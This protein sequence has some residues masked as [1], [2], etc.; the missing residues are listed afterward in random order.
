MEIFGKEI[1]SEMLL[2]GTACLA[3]VEKRPESQF[4]LP[5]RTA[6]EA[7]ITKSINRLAQKIRSD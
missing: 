7:A 3:R 5:R 2:N 1:L 6:S 4:N